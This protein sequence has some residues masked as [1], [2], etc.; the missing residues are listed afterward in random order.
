MHTRTIALGA[1]L[2]LGLAT[3]AQA[4]QCGG[5]FAAWRSAVRAE[6]A[7]DGIGERGLSALEAARIDETVLQRDRAQGVF[8]Q[9]FI[10]FSG[11]MINDYRLKNGAAN[12]SKYAD[13][14]ARA[15]SEFG[16]PGPVIASFWALETDFGAVQGDFSTLNAL[17]TLAHDCRR[18]EIFRPQLV[19]LLHLIDQGWIGADVTGAWAGEIGQM[20]M[21]PSDY[22]TKGVDGDGDGRVDLKGSAPD[23]ILTAARNLQS[24]GWKPGQPWLEEVRVPD[25]MPWE[26]TGLVNPLPRSEWAAMGVTRRDGSP[27]ENDAMQAGLILPMGHRGPAFLAFEN[28]DIYLEWNQSLIYTLTAAHLAARLDGAPRFDPRSPEQGLAPEMMKQ[29]QQKLAGRG[30]DVGKIDGILGAGTRGAVRQEQLRL[31]LPADGWPTPTLFS[32]L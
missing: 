20:Q 11:R 21:L 5:D 19:A 7:N 1:L 8:N 15:Q 29:L 16:I 14:F 31:G 23:A 22:Y 6:A 4:Q 32:N 3:A 25:Q 12:L 27:L 30:H 2:A 13:T 9:T 24:L 17:A 18:P 26:K 10:E 28:Y